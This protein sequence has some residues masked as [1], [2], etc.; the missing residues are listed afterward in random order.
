M[1]ARIGDAMERERAF[2]ADA[3][4]ELRTPLAILRAELDLA[5]AEGRSRDELRA[6]LA[7]AAEETDRLTQLSEDLLTIAQTEARPSCRCGSSRCASATSSNRSSAASPAAPP[8]RGGRSSVGEGG[9]DRAA[10]RP[11]CA[12]TR[13]SA[14][15]STTRSAT[16]AGRSC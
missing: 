16:A 4:H 7:S 6:A 5:L 1:L 15:S 3:G 11:G 10:R 13:P 8:K 14:P 9:E 2:V 12:S